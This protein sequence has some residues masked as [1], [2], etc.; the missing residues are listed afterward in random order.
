MGIDY[1]RIILV[2][3]KDIKEVINKLHLQQP[4]VPEDELVMSIEFFLMAVFPGLLNSLKEN[5]F[6]QYKQGYEDGYKDSK[7]DENTEGV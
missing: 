7:N 2:S 1:E 5:M 6:Q 4:E 3:V